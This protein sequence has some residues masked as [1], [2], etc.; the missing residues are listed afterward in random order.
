[1]SPA[2]RISLLASACLCAPSPA[3]AYRTLADVEGSPTP[4]V[5]AAPPSVALDVAGLSADDASVLTA[6][7]REAIATWNAASCRGDIARF[8][9]TATDADVVVRMVA[10]WAGGGFDSTAA[11]VADLVLVS[12]A[13]DGV[14]RIEIVG[15][16]L[17]LNGTMT[18]GPHPQDGGDVRDLRVVLVH[19]LGH[20]L[21][22]EHSDDE[23]A[24][25]FAIYRRGS[26][27]ADLAADDIAGLCAIYPALTP[28]CA[29]GCPLACVDGECGAPASE[30]QCGT[31]R[32]CAEGSCALA[33]NN[34]GYCIPEGSSGV[35]CERGADCVSGLC[36]SGSGLAYCTVQCSYDDQCAGMQRCATVEGR[37]VCAPLGQSGCSVGDGRQALPWQWLVALAAVGLRGRR[38]ARR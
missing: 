23:D 38:G 28:T 25:M 29:A 13:T 26:A 5:W 36:V 12:A 34:E 19:E 17:S 35:A 20:C 24:T 30:P 27:Q 6:E 31:D 7:L 2:L 18:W 22:L 8:A 1:M 9:G 11:G 32:P 4:I 3:L 15:A 37:S 33:G 14:A 10:D 21:G 16:T